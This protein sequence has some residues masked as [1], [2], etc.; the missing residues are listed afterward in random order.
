MILFGLF[1]L[2]NLLFHLF[3]DFFCSQR[4]SS[5]WTPNQS[6]KIHLPKRRSSLPRPLQRALTPLPKHVNLK[7]RRPIKR[8]Q[9]KN[10]LKEQW[11]NVPELEVQ[12]EHEPEPEH[13]LTCLAL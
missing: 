7:Q 9:P 2:F 5:R 8:L 11:P 10:A 6:S 13:Q 1:R 3:R 4:L 12:E